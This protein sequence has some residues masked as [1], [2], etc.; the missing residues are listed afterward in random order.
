MPPRTNTQLTYN[1]GDLQLAL[2]AIEQDQNLSERRAADIHNVPQ[3]TLSD[4]RARKVSRRDCTPNLIKLLKTKEEVIIQHILDLDSRGFPPRLAAVKD[5]ADSLLAARHQDPVGINWASTF[6]Q[7]TP[8][9]KVKFNQ[10]YN[11]K[12]ALCEDPKVIA[13]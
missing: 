8:E 10:K 13:L 7:R 6:V 2:Q 5:M 1:E 3:K 12:R 11:Y 4:R 9:L